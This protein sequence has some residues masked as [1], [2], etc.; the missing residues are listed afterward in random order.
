MQR[1]LLLVSAHVIQTTPR[2][3]AASSLLTYT[4][5]LRPCSSTGSWH[6]VHTSIAY[7]HTLRS[8]CH[9]AET[10]DLSGDL[11]SIV[12]RHGAELN[13]AIMHSRDF[14]LK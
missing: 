2:S 9:A 6:L 14:D 11:V 10:A 1:L 3:L 7:K 8:L 12:E 4:G 13:G 5:P